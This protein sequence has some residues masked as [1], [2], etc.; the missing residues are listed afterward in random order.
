MLLDLE[1]EEELEGED[2]EEQEEDL[3]ADAESGLCC[4]DCGDYFLSANAKPS[5]CAEC[6]EAEEDA[7][8]K[9]AYP[10]S[11]YPVRV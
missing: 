6:Y 5:L 9:P 4:V 3:A 11:E 8:V 10:K 7:G 1:G 2:E